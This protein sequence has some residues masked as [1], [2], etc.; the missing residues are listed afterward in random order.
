M[1]IIDFKE[2]YE[3]GNIE[4]LKYV[5]STKKFDDLFKVTEIYSDL[6]YF[7]SESGNLDFV[8]FILSVADIDLNKIGKD[9]KISIL[10]LN[11]PS[12]FAACKSDNLDL[13]KYLISLDKIDLNYVDILY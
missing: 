12:F 9:R 6:L 7:A 3:S 10:F 11:V 5:I 1:N 13:I 8:K 2:I 4:V